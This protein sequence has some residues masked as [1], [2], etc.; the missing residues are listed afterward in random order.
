[1]LK[2]ANNQVIG[3]S[4]MYSSEAAMENGISSV[5]SSAPGAVVEE[6]G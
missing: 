3:T 4:E 6:V 5:K 1:V 2:A